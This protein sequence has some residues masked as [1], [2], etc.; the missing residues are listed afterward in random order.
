MQTVTGRPH[1]DRAPF[2]TLREMLRDRARRFAQTPAFRYHLKPGGEEIVRTYSEFIT[3]IDQFGTGLLRLGLAGCHLVVIGDN[4]YEWA[5]AHSAIINGVGVS[6]PIDK[7]LPENEVASLCQRGEADAFIYGPKHHSIALA[8]AARNQRIRYF[9]CMRQGLVT[10]DLQVRDSRFRDFDTVLA[11][12]ASALADGDRQYMD[13]PLDPARMSSLLFTSGTTAMAKG[14][15]LSQ[16]NIV[17]NLNAAMA[18]IDLAAGQQALSLL[19]LHH[20]L[21]NTIGMYLLLAFGCCICYSDGLRYLVDNL[22]EWRINLVLAVPLLFENIYH[23]IHKKLEKTGKLR[24]VNLLRKVCR[25][26]RKIRIDVRRKVFSQIIDNLGGGLSL[27]VCGA[28]AIDRQVVAF[29]EEIGIDFWCGYGLT[30]TSPVISVC[31]RFVNV[32][33]SVGNPLAT[34]EVAIDTSQPEPGAIGEILTRSDSVMLGYYQ[35]PAATAEV[36]TEDGW[37]RTGDIGFLDKTRSLHITG[38]LKSMIVLTNGKKAFPEEIEFLVNRIEGVKESIVWGEATSHD[39]V[40]ISAKIVINREALP[41]GAA[42][43]AEQLSAW[44]ATQ[45]KSINKDMPTYKAIKYF[46][47]TEQDLIKTTTLKVRRPDELRRIHAWLEQQG[48]TM[49]TAS[50]RQSTD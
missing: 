19:P 48:Q 20:T 33:G 38:R 11:D 4:S 28:A 25:L 8:V 29:F 35:N 27:C 30:E 50:G 46:V 6:V 42:E 9:I 23:T 7:Q 21:E 49:R 10:A 26:L 41:A 47:W 39:T 3:A 24:T 15:M 13:C 43:S 31:N 17:H 12:G 22:K 40:D 16:R 18:T 36:M 34:V 2:A 45:I 5:I 37:F 32:Y 44:L 1:Y 14:V